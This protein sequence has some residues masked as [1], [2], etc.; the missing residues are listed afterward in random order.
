MPD[1]A[2]DHTLGDDVRLV[3]VLVRPDWVTNKGGRERAA[4]FVFLDGL[5]HEVSCFI[6]SPEARDALRI[7]YPNLQVAVITV[8]AAT[9]S[10][11]IVA[12]DDEGGAGIPGHVVLVQVE[13][14]QES[15][16][17]IRRTKQ[18]AGDSTVEP[19]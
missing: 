2:H 13:A 1:R 19:L 4:S 9:R 14:E 15:K 10:G 18:L 7:R 8:G 17:H 5:T 3:R 6:D 12:R 11:H 16:D